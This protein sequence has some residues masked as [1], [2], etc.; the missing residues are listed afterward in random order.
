MF[1]NAV[2]TSQH[3][4]PSHHTYTIIVRKIR[5]RLTIS[6]LWTRRRCEI[7]VKCVLFHALILV[8]KRDFLNYWVRFRIFGKLFKFTMRGREG[9]DILKLHF[10]Y[11][12]T[13]EK[14]TMCMVFTLNRPEYNFLFKNWW[15]LKIYTL[16][17]SF[18]F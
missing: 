17:F 12:N 5:S 14:A 2:S 3:Y 8:G 7:H 1:C 13:F 10:L 9:G 18:S 16:C 15:I 6:F 11:K 4:T